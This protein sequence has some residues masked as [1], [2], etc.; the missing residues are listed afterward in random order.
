MSC[1]RAS[2]WPHSYVTNQLRQKGIDDIHV[3]F[4]LEMIYAPRENRVGW[5][6]SHTEAYERLM[7]AKVPE[8]LPELWNN[9]LRFVAGV[10]PDKS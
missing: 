5:N 10:N 7:A 8:F 1:C 2:T 4:A 9:T 3:M 6:S